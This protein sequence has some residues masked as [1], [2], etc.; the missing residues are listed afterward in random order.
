MASV[1]S[2]GVHEPAGLRFAI[3]ENI[4]PP[5]PSPELY[6]WELF[7]DENGEDELFTTET[8]AIWSRGGE[9]G[10]C[11]RFDI[12]KEPISK[13]LLA[14]FPTGEDDADQGPSASRAS[15][16]SRSPARQVLAKSLVVFLK[17]QAHVYSFSGG[18]H[19]VHMPFEIE[20][21]IAAPYGV[22][23]QRKSKVD[24]TV[25]VTLKFPR[26]P[27]NSFVSSQILPT[28][29][30]TFMP[31]FS[32]AS[33]GKP[34]PLPLRLSSTLEAMWDTPL[35][36]SDVGWPRLV[37][38]TDPML[39]LGLIV[40]QPDRA[41]KER[42]P[43]AAIKTPFLDPAE[44]ILHVETIPLDGDVQR[45]NSIDNRLILAVTVNRET[46]MYSVWRMSYLSGG[47]Q[48]TRRRRAPKTKA[49]RRR[50]SMQPGLASGATTPHHANFRESLN[51]TL[52]VKKTRK[53]ERHDKDKGDGPLEKVL[54]LEP[55]RASEVSR[56]Q[57]RRVSS[58][59]ARA[60]LSASHERP[61][62]AE[63]PTLSTTG[64]RRADS[65]HGS[66]RARVGS[67]Y[68]AAGVNGG[69]NQTLN[70]LL[71]APVDGLLEE[72]RSGGD[73]E[74]F[75][76]MGLEDPEFDGLSKEI[77]FT[78]I[79]SVPMDT[80]NI[81]YSLSNTPAA[82]LCKVFV[83]VGTPFSVDEQDRNY[84]LVCIQD[85]IDKR[86]Q[87]LTLHV[88]A[89]NKSG[90][91]AGGKTVSITWGQLRRAQNVVDSC[92]VHD[93][94]QAMILIL[95]EGDDGQRQLSIQAPWSELTTIPLPSLS[96]SVRDIFSINTNKN[97]PT[98]AVAA[99]DSHITGLR[100]PRAKGVVD[101][102]DEDGR[103]HQIQIRMEPR[104]TRV[105]QVLDVLRSVLPAS[106]A[107]KVVTGWW[108]VMQWLG[109]QFNDDPAN[110]E[111]TAL[112]VELCL[113]YLALMQFNGNSSFGI[114]RESQSSHDPFL[115]EKNALMQLS[116]VNR[117]PW[118][119]SKAWCWVS[120]ET[121]TD[122]TLT[123]SGTGSFEMGSNQ[124][125]LSTSIQLARRYMLST[126]GNQ[127][128]G[129]LG[130]LPTA[131]G[132]AESTRK[133]AAWGIV[134]AL[135]LYLEEEKLDVMASAANES[136]S[137]QLK[138]LVCQM[139]KWLKWPSFVELYQLELDDGLIPPNELEKM[140]CSVAVA[141]PTSIPSIFEWIR[142]RITGQHPEPFPTLEDVY[143]V[144]SQQS[145]K[146]GGFK[147][148]DSSVQVVETIRC[149]QHPPTHWSEELFELV[150]RGDIN[151]VLK[152]DLKTPYDPSNLLVPQG[153]NIQNMDAANHEM[154]TR[155]SD[156]PESEERQIIIQA[157][158]KD[159]KRLYEAQSL[160]TSSK[161]RV[162]RLNPEPSWSESEYLERQKEL[163]TTIA[164][165]T[166]ATSAGRGMLNYGFR[167]PLLTQKFNVQGFNLTCIVKPTNVAVGV[168]KSMFTEE[169]VN[170]AFF[171]QGV[172][173][174]LAISAR[175]KGIDTSWIVFNKPGTDLSHR[176]AGFL[177]ALGL[178]G[179]LKSVA[180]WVAFRYLTPK[181]MMTSIGLLLGLAVSHLGTMDSL[182][183]RLLS[184]HVTRMLPRGAAELNLSHQ[185][186]TT[187]I[188]GIGLLYYNS[189]HRRM[190]EI[191][192]S[193]IEY[194][195]DEDEEDPLRNEG[196]RLAA[197]FAL[198]FINLGKGSDRKGL[199]DMRI[200]EQLL[201]LA[202]STKKVE[203]VNVLDR[204]A[205]AATVAIALI[206][207][208][209]EDQIV[210]RKI[211][212]PDSAL[213]FDY[214]RPDILLLRT[215]AKNLI[216]WSNIEG[217]F[218]WVRF[219]LP[220][221]FQGRYK[222]DD[223]KSLRSSDLSFFA[224]ITGLCFA[225]AFRFAG[226]ANSRVRDMLVHYLD[227]F[228]QIV[229]E[230]PAAHF[231]AQ[232]ARSGARMCM[233]VLALSCATVMAGT[234][235]LV[236]L[237]RLRA[238]HGRDDVH[239]T[240]GSHLA[241]HL[242]IGALFLGS[243]T[244]TFGNNNLAVAALLVA[245]YPIFPT[246][247]QD[248]GSHLQAFRHFW[249]LATEPR[250]LVTK[251][252][253]TNQP[254]SV[255][256]LIFLKRTALSVSS[257]VASP[258]ETIWRRQTPCLLP[259]LDDI[260]AV[261]TDASAQGFWDLE[262]NFER[263]PSLKQAFQ[264]NQ[265][266]YLRRRPAHESA[267]ATTLQALSCGPALGMGAPSMA[268]DRRADPLEWV[269]K[270]GTFQKL[271]STE[272]AYILG[273]PGTSEV[274][275][276]RTLSNNID[277]RLTLENSLDAWKR[278]DLLDLRLLIDWAD[279]RHRLRDDD[280]GSNT[281]KGKGPDDQQ[282]QAMSSPWSNQNRNVD[283]WLRDNAIDMLKGKIWLAGQQD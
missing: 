81:R 22:I 58:L 246:S 145:Y 135:H 78:K 132:L 107:E 30:D 165:S 184:V 10:R 202:S 83:V 44:E 186:Q 50:S 245:F 213:Q 270:L 125:V 271:S 19:V 263:D 117:R 214:V 231:D 100:H 68:S 37:C 122:L 168:D 227:R 188:I 67:S 95:S 280:S 144:L 150:G 25:P 75:Q 55:D 228:M 204:S 200:T 16:R 260:I 164:T 148:T 74:G 212:I 1:T 223:V 250:C 163:V 129:H 173:Y 90:A 172:A 147:P 152:P 103:F 276:S 118:L 3:A 254:I 264:S 218:D 201:S 40:T 80:A 146:H 142:L 134:V 70:S 35:E 215:L 174:G 266:L 113:V 12:E 149:Q 234:G 153:E 96:A 265:N 216:L 5:D 99:F 115:S 281:D 203:L 136:T 237:R 89:R 116:G 210:A 73:F 229:Q 261:R 240:Y 222:L 243:G 138:A 249:V 91:H 207:L 72:L 127:A 282:D 56:R 170:W 53:S 24:A 233:D 199:L 211:D 137:M 126:A 239:T 244:T 220:L 182:I 191:M 45:L 154:N 101:V 208:K 71:E 36:A 29:N 7:S 224:I 27:P 54:S 105:R 194:M 176:H 93:G 66:Q 106:Y 257:S 6:D 130:Y 77:L 181:H 169:K 139:A 278:D 59:L 274:G 104:S 13:A 119:R 47:D 52:P 97:Q 109:S 221:E 38:L 256:L 26:V 171:H 196:Y 92:K 102:V 195:E 219:S 197:A 252:A 193:E 279:Q 76:N 4:L 87:L 166:L 8:C 43:R 179:H 248:N 158:F 167:F 269:F 21:A 177:L 209:T 225:A 262:I 159:D 120:D 65:S 88:Q 46:S 79:R 183:T 15:H 283:W 18:D 192:M 273:R 121:L 242:A 160:L 259:P 62:F 156:E 60:D 112:T 61:L 162:V 277:V 272:R 63:Q 86:L 20:S 180:K 69:Y 28:P 51:G 238:L 255:P 157:L 198:G 128:V 251:N 151:T 14:Y 236:V 57:S 189:Q 206:F 217:T 133:G 268:L 141:E 247:I 275:N 32:T 84:L 226:S 235:D 9:I 48:L 123:D 232:I 230:L 190:S 94:H 23:I 85:T 205:A 33:L 124:G 49:T 111:W 185:I 42:N 41:S 161:P 178:N 131:L 34:K 267:L 241:A 31:A 253:A 175:A 39:E 108:H 110:I 98:E 187:G 143:S 2:L 82:K 155:A 11:L 114:E 17:T 258:D 140:S 64:G